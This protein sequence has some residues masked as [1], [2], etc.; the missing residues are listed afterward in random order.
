MIG[1]KMLQ[2]QYIDVLF[3]R[4][5]SFK[6]SEQ[7]EELYK[8]ETLTSLNQYFQTEEI[9]EETIVDI[10]RN[11]QKSNPSQ[12]SFVHW[13]NT[14]DLVKYA[15]AKPAE[16]VALLR[17]LYDPTQPLIDRIETFRLKGKEFQSTLSLGAPFWLFACSV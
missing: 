15:E 10:V 2:D 13:S 14:E 3:K 9:T 12:G 4:Y 6:K 17:N 16:V 5:K 7:Y 11:F 8:I 1:E